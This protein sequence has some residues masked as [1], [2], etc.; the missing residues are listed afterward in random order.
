MSKDKSY[1]AFDTAAY[2]LSF[3]ARTSKE[4]TDK[5]LQRGYEEE[6]IDEAISKLK[7]YGYVNDYEYAMSY[8]RGNSRR[9]GTKLIAMELSGKGI[10]KDMFLEALE[11]TGVD[12]R[13]AILNVITRRYSDLEDESVRRRAY[14]YFMRKGYKSDDINCAISSHLSSIRESK[15]DDL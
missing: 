8:I 11:V 3:K 6:Q 7:D 12:E 15:K 5:L 14:A 2:Y 13:Q 9:K 1:S 10:D 4:L